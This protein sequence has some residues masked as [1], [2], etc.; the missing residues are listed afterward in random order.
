M[1]SNSIHFNSIASPP[2]TKETILIFGESMVK[3]VNG[4][5]PTDIIKQKYLVKV[6]PFSP[7]KTNSMHDN[8]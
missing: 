4:L 6:R 2:K 3:K 5:S 8:N 1:N 7:A